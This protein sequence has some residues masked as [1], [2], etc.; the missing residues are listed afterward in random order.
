VNGRR[1]G[2]PVVIGFLATATAA[3]GLAAFRAN[4]S[5]APP[6]PGGK[7]GV[8]GSVAGLSVSFEAN[9]GQT[10]PSVRFLSRAGG[11][12]AFL[13]DSGAVFSIPEPGGAAD[14]AEAVSA[15]LTMRLVGAASKP[16]VVGGE[17][18][19]GIVNYFTDGDPGEWRTGIPTYGTVRYRGV[20]P[21]IDLIF[22]GLRTG[23]EYDF[24]VSPGADPSRVLL[25]F[26][27]AQ[28]IRIDQSG[29]LVLKTAA[30]PLVHRAP[31]IY[32][33]VEGLR[34]EIAGG[35]RLD[36]DAVGFEIGSYDASRPLVIDPL[37]YSTFLGG[38]DFDE[39]FGIAVDG[40]GRAYVTG[41][42]ES[43]NFPTTAGVHDDS[44]NG[45]SSNGTDVFVTR[46]SPDGAALEY[47]TFLGSTSDEFGEDI[48]V[49]SSGRAYVTG[50]VD[51][52]G[53][54]FP[55]TPGA[56]DAT[57]NE[58]NDAFITRLTPSGG[59]GYSTFLGS[60]EGDR[61]LA[62]AA[63]GSGRAYVTGDTG[64]SVGF[65]T[66]PDA[67]DTNP[68][69]FIDAFVTRFTPDGTALEYSTFLG[70]GG[71]DHGESIAVDQAG[72]AYVTGGA[73]GAVIPF[74]TTETAPDTTHNGS[75]DAFVTRFTASGDDL[76][77][78][79]FL[80]GALFDL[81]EGVAIHGSE[82]A[83]VVGATSSPNFPT[84]AG[85]I[86]TTHN[87]S[88]D[89]F[90]TRLNASGTTLES[91]SFLGGSGTDNGIDIAT[92]ATG[93]AYV[94]GST[95]DAVT[96]L[97]TT[98]GAFD[99]THNGTFDAFVTRI[100]SDAAVLDYSTFLGG[101]LLEAGMGID[102]AGSTEAY[103]TGETRDGP[104]DFPTT[105]GA[106]DTSP[107][108]GDDAFVAK[109]ETSLPSPAH[110]V[111]VAGGGFSTKNRID[112]SRQ[113]PGPYDVKIK[114]KNFGDVTEDIGYSVS[115]D[116]DEV[117]LGPECSGTVSGVA[118]GATATV[119]GCTAT[120]SGADDPDP[121]L[122]LNV[123]HNNLDGFSDGNTGNN[124]ETVATVIK[125]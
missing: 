116:P 11:Y 60:T 110:D 40:S 54:D 36:G 38:A 6:V 29:S 120:Y 65:P 104:T 91:S 25:R 103:V 70:G 119:V 31:T 77:Y 16:D 57:H 39:G 113:G 92:D 84:T 21:G 71:N 28:G 46:L 50:W 19:P 24:I 7:E 4:R 14:Q 23:I 35:Y 108:G 69:G 33:L 9:R 109:V 13:T 86:D 44:H 42:T 22:R 124:S 62:I 95:E 47:S 58:N 100:S 49:D 94:T 37:V 81:G 123:T 98:V 93:R 96:D 101:S 105:P 26:G 73:S 99:T 59:L 66:T 79:T 64:F 78:S 106:F 10:D 3:G 87:G 122:T 41:Y 8:V 56:F 17:R 76:E 112:L 27:G 20:Y 45:G 83:Y 63:D 18:L 118:P 121:V 97:P 115:A 125:P 1:L 74:P 117:A 5:A 15:A 32:Q 114:L 82:S 67:Y 85:S 2:R 48:A 68:N 51:P 12:T 111:G 30:G 89:A 43:T 107:N 90:V 55:T 80:G 75:T 53:T 34:R 102:V 61:G 52:G 72:R 88:T